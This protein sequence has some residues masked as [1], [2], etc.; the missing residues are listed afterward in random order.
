MTGCVLL[1]LHHFDLL[2]CFPLLLL[3]TLLFTLDL[4]RKSRIISLFKVSCSAT[5]IPLWHVCNMFIVSGD[6]DMDIFGQAVILPTTVSLS[7]RKILCLS[8]S[9]YIILLYHVFLIEMQFTITS[10][11][12]KLCQVLVWHMSMCFSTCIFVSLSDLPLTF[13]GSYSFLN[14]YIKNK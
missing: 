10:Y 14:P 3:R 1:T 9:F 8:L 13:L 7:S 6:W 12:F 11:K 4:P 2:F 5:L